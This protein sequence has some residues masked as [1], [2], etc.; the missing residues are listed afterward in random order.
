MIEKIDVNNDGEIDFEE[1]K[2]LYAQH[3]DNLYQ[4]Y[5]NVFDRNG[6]KSISKAELRLGFKDLGVEMLDEEVDEI[7]KE[8]DVN[9][10][11]H[12]TFDEFEKIFKDK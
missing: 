4:D 7:I 2:Q 11:N 8:F 1:F 5:F 9:H 6:S 3:H 12:I 10:D